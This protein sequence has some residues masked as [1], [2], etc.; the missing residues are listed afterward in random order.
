MLLLNTCGISIYE[1]CE[2]AK[3]R[4][5]EKDKTE[6]AD[7]FVSISSETDDVVYSPDTV[8]VATQ[9]DLTVMHLSALQEDNQRM[10]T[11]L[12][13]VRVAKGYPSHED[14]KSGE[15][16]FR[17]YTGLSSFTVLMA[18]IRCHFGGRSSQA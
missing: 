1:L 10:M 3:R 11:E 15:K 12:A 14:L 16:A 2:A 18:G 9:T 4:Q 5:E 8:T 7:S 6:A 17:I 13:E